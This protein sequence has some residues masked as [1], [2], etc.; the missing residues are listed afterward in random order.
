[1]QTDAGRMECLGRTRTYAGVLG[2][3]RPAVYGALLSIT[4]C[5]TR[6]FERGAREC[7]QTHALP[8]VSETLSVGHAVFLASVARSS[9]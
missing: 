4:E 2:S 9:T 7:L 5:P 6:R 8:C 3:P 1:M